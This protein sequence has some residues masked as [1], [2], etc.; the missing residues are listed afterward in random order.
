MKLLIQLFSAEHMKM[1]REV[2]HAAS[3]DEHHKQ[4]EDHEAW[5]ATFYTRAKEFPAP[6]MVNHSWEK[7]DVLC[8]NE[9]ANPEVVLWLED[10][11]KY[12]LCQTDSFRKTIN[13]WAHIQWQE[14]GFMLRVA[15]IAEKKRLDGVREK[16]S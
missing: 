9:L 6:L 11:L 4:G 14:H 1:Q 5:R 3:E 7:R 2:I 10:E 12:W 8:E 15:L 16:L 13:V